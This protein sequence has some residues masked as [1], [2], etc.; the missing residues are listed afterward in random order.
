M[1]PE[2]RLGNSFS[3]ATPCQYSMGQK[4][5]YYCQGR[6]YRH[7]QPGAIG[8]VCSQLVTEPQ[9]P[10]FRR[11]CRQG[12]HL[13][14]RQHATGIY[15]RCRQTFPSYNAAGEAGGTNLDGLGGFETLGHAGRR[16]SSP[17]T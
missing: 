7:D 12:E 16:P 1:A 9:R 15:A 3:C 2:Q 17:R 10:G 14:S 8:R 6:Q 4:S 13:R 11:T 5:E